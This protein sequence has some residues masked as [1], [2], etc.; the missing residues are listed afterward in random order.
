M[1]SI[2]L[3]ILL[4]TKIA[5]SQLSGTYYVGSGQTYTSLTGSGASGFFNAVNT[6]GLSGDVTVYIVSDISESGGVSLNQWSGNFTITI[7]PN[8]ANVYNLT[9][10]TGSP[11]INLNGADYLTI[12]GSFNGSGRYLRFTNLNTSNPLIRFIN[13]A[14]NNTITS[15]IIEGANTNSS[16]GLVLF[17]TTT[18]TTGNDNN[19]ISDC[20]IRN[21]GG[22][23]LNAIYSSGTTSSTARY[24]SGIVI[25]NNE[26]TDFYRNGFIASGVTLAEGSTEW[27]ISNN[28]FYQTVSRN[29][30]SAS[31]W[32]VIHISTSHANNI[33]IS[34]NHLG[35]S[36]ANCGGDA[37]TCT[38]NVTNTLVLI[39]FSNAGTTTSSNI[40]NNIIKNFSITSTP[41][42]GGAVLFAG[43]SVEGGLVNSSGNIIGDSASTDNITLNYNGSTNN[44]INRGI[45]YS[46]ATGNISANKIGSIKINGNNTSGLAR[47][48]GI[49]Y[50]GTPSSNVTIS[51]NLIGSASASGSINAANPSMYFQ[52]TGIYSTIN[53]VTLNVTGN[54]IIN[55]VNTSS[56]SNAWTRGIFQ[57]NSTSAVCNFQNNVVSELYS[58]GTNTSRFPNSCPIIGIYT[59]S[60]STTQT[61]SGNIISGLR[62]DANANVHVQGF[63]HYNNIG[64]GTFEKNRIYDLTNSST[65]S[66]PKI[67][68][69]NAFWGSWKFYNN[70][71]TLTNGENTANRYSSEKFAEDY[72][73][74]S[75]FT[76]SVKDDANIYNQLIKDE[77]F[78][79]TD[80]RQKSDNSATT[81]STNGVEIKGIHD[82]AEFDCYFYYNSIYI[83]GTATSGNSSSWAYDRPLTSWPTPA[84]IT[85]NLFFNGRTGGTGKHYAIGNEIGSTNWTSTSANYNVYIS[86][87]QNT[88]GIWGTSDQ[89]IDQWRT[90]SG[91]DKHT[92]STISSSLNASNLFS[93]ISDGNLSVNTGNYEAWIVSGKGIALSSV[94]SDYSGNSRSTSISGGCTDIGAHE[95][96]ATPPDCPQATEINSPGSGVTSTYRLWGRNLVVINWGTGGSQYPSTVSVKYYSSV[97]PPGTSGG[98]YSNSHW[99]IT[100]TGTL[101]GT[102]YDITFN[103]GDNETYTITSPNVNTRI[104]KYVSSWEIFSTAGTGAWQTELNWSNH[105]AKTR[106]MHDFSVYAL[107]DVNNPLPVDLCSFTART[108]GRNIELRWT[109]CWEINNRGFEIERRRSPVNYGSYNNW[110]KIGFVQGAGNSNE[111]INYKFADNKLIAGKYQYRLKQIDYNGNHEYYVLNSPSEILIDAPVKAELY[112]NYPNPSNPSSRIEFDIPNSSVVTLKV[113]DIAGREVL[114]IADQKYEAG[115]YTVEFNGSSLAS[116]IYFYRLTVTND[117]GERYSKTLRLVLIK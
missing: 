91:G 1:K 104:A 27:T 99:D 14:T 25:S 32:N 75:Y 80:F 87:N 89:T 24:N 66:S 69:I 56:N 22:N 31:G 10:N 35:G 19:T 60:N 100:P 103:F 51:N 18:G 92:W 95:F 112:Q 86:S 84:K 55:M 48:E 16:S 105:N 88:I 78:S 2:S 46:N 30:T 115:Y 23:M 5:Y 113:Y 82:E 59:G 102:T 68:G 61:V 67:W 52:M 65:S 33:T 28:S 110:E 15:C 96:S 73:D 9:G 79:Y 64:A 107:T 6:Q 17:S 21:S 57:N 4:I 108:S 44:I 71:I 34:G 53:T 76:N 70:Q 26:I 114:T 93:N 12:D 36:S 13:D 3:I 106:G 41:S 20:L 63:A 109:T 58:S 49:N 98:N 90:S 37:W 74:N 72:I 11:L 116:G 94:N 47:F 29:N 8:S 83:G 54:R 62:S 45:N 42:S 101:S 81:F 40:N 39:R 97:N 77:R 111:E 43:I 117:A 85:N 7:K 38:G 50:T